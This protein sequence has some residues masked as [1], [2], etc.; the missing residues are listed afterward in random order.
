MFRR[1]TSPPSLVSKNKPSKRDH[2]ESNI[3][4]LFQAGLLPGLFF[5]PEDGGDKFLRNVGWLSPNYIVLCLRRRTSFFF[6][7]LY[8]PLGPWPLLFQFHDLF[9]DGRT[10]WTSDQ[11]VAWPLPKHRTPQTQNKHI[12][13]PNIHALCGIRTHDPGYRDRR[14]QTSTLYFVR[15]KQKFRTV[16]M[17]VIVNREIIFQA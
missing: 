7:L 3:C 2:H 12:H 15:Y 17:L 16:V 10:P 8:S 14:R 9:T 5:D 11:L 6:H 1:N 13:T 4:C